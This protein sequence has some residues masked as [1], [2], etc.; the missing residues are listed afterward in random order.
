M[1]PDRAALYRSMLT[2]RRLEEGIAELWREGLISGEMHLGIGEEAIVAGVVDHLG[3]GDALAL[4]HRPTAAMVMHGVDPGA[5]VR[6]CL[7]RRDGL[8]GGNGGHM[9][10]F[11]K[12]HLAASSGIVGSSGPAACGF[13]L[14][15]QHCRPG[16]VAV[17]FFGEGAM[18]QGMLMESMNLAACWKLPVLFVCKDNQVAITTASASVTG[19]DLLERARGLGLGARTVDGVDV[20]E[21]WRAAGEMIA[22]ARAGGGPGFL[23]AT[24]TRPEGHMLGDPLLRIVRQPVGELKGRVGPLLSAAASLDGSR[25][26]ERAASLSAVT[27]SLGR[28]AKM[29]LA[30]GRDPVA[31]LRRRLDLGRRELAALEAAVAEE[32]AAA[33]TVGEEAVS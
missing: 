13:A 8:C 23:H 24:C 28:A 12:A 1:E 22:S 30:P 16:K 5:I 6:E 3:E 25:I 11:S 31:R 29:I 26:V 17:A 2:C 19:G 9:H 18:N 27:G 32:V 7:G 33:L 4:D 10:L 20:D 21:V 15:H 14:A